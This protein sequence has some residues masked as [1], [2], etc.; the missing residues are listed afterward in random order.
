MQLQVVDRLVELPY[1]L[2]RS[3]RAAVSTSPLS[4]Q[5]LARVSITWP[6]RYQWAHA[7]GFTETVKTALARLGVLRVEPTSQVHPGV[8]MLSCLVDGRAIMVALEYSDNHDFINEQALADCSLYIK[9]Q[10]REKGYPDSRIIRGGYPVTGLDYYRYYRAFRKRYVGGRRIDVLGR[11][12]YRFQE[13]LRRKAVEMLSAAPDIDF[14]GRGPR[15][16]YSRFLR[17]A[18]SARLCLDLPG[19]GPFTFRVPEF[20]GL[21]SC[22]IAP[23]YTTALHEPLVPGVHYVAIADDLSDL[24]DSCRYYLSHDHEREKIAIAGREFF[25][26]YLHCDHLAA[27]YVRNILDRLG[28]RDGATRSFAV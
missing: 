1:R 13:E 2:C 28:D 16:R 20:L 4:A 3:S 21:G 8:V 10:F 6:S 25:D 15:V 9:F 19:N 26:R 5:E 12:G 24:L 18:A 22:M 17:E 11:F 14:V 7:A 23:R 27:Y